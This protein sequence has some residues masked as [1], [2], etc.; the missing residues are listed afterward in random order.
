M[1]ISLRLCITA[2]ALVS[3]SGQLASAQ[4]TVDRESVLLNPANAGERVASVTVQNTGTTDVKLSVQLEDWDVDA[5]G[6][7]HW[8]KAGAVAGSCGRRVAVSPAALQLAPG[9]QGIVRVA[10]KSDAKFDAECWSAAVVRSIDASK[11]DSSSVV[12]N[13]VPLF[14]TPS[15]LNLDGELSDMFVT[16]DS[17]EV[18]FRNTGKQ[19][20]NIVGEVQVQTADEA[21][22]V[23]VP[24]DA[25]TVLVGATRKFRVAMPK[26][27]RGKYVLVAMVD[28][29]GDQLTA[30]QAA[31]D[32]R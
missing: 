5:H 1:R 20:A 8:R 13:T 2:L 30:V 21:V 32:M 28:F 16:G 6:A 27:P 26:L 14:V 18:I 9:Q 15:G 25:T 22:V 4:I 23:A 31:L 29:G 11:T 10:L 24:L 7:S 3:A 12:Y 17:L 19:R